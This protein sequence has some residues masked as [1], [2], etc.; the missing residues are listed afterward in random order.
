MAEKSPSESDPD[1][2]VLRDA[3]NTATEIDV[4]YREGNV[5]DRR[6]LRKPR[7]DAFGEYSRV[8]LELLKAGTITT[9][10][11]VK[12]MKAIRGAVEAAGETQAL[13]IAIGRFISFLARF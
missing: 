7:D 13:I 11:D 12:D 4:R 2:K 9:A 6:K 8:R 10:A 3:G 1:A 5:N